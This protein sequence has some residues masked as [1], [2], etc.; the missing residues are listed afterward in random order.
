MRLLCSQLTSDSNSNTLRNR[1]AEA[2]PDYDVPDILALADGGIWQER[3]AAIIILG[4]RIN[5]SPDFEEDSRIAVMM[6]S[7]C[8]DPHAHVRQRA[9]AMLRK[10]GT[11]TRAKLVADIRDRL[12]REVD[13]SAK[14]ELQA[15][16]SELR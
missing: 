10:R 14:K 16:L 4:Q 13:N 15:L 8:N 3:V 5:A 12:S 1:I 11:R 7:L 9:Y 6:R 2:A